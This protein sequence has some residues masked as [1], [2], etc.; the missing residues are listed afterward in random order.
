[1]GQMKELGLEN[2]RITV[3]GVACMLEI[4]FGAVQSILKFNLNML[5]I[6]AK[7]VLPLLMEEQQKNYQL[8]LGPSKEA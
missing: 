5:C 7:F 8:T 4:L 2:R 1:M 3:S 6:A